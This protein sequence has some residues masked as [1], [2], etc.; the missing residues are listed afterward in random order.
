MLKILGFA[1]LGVALASIVLIPMV[2]A[3]TGNKRMGI[4]NLTYL[5]YPSFFY[6]RLF[7]I[8]VSN[9]CPYDL[10]LGFVAPTILSL[11]LVVKNFKK[12]KML[13][14]INVMCLVFICLPICGKAFNAFKFATQRWSFAVALPIS[15]SLAYEWDNFVNEKSSIIIAF[16]GACMLTAYSAWSRNER[17]IIPMLFCFAF[18]VIVL[19]NA[20]NE[21]YYSIKNFS[22]LLIIVFNIFYIYKMLSFV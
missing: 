4:E 10:C 5:F 20:R 18:M 11:F 9:D 7:T 2:I 19:Q 21:R 16:I 14:I 6:E 22:L 3:Y 17:V 1:I 12:N 15:Y 8:F 13:A